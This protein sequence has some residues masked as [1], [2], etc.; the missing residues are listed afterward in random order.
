MTTP[1]ELSRVSDERDRARAMAASLEAELAQLRA[2]LGALPAWR[3]PPTYVG[4]KAGE[5]VSVVT[6][7]DILDV[8]RTKPEGTP[9]DE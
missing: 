8:L 6:A 3:V 5:W 1:V 4:A 7:P 2:K 9:S